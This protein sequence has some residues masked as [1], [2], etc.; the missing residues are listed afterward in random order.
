MNRVT[1]SLFFSGLFLGSGPCLAICGPVLIS[2]IVATRLNTK[3]AIGAWFLFS[4]SRICVYIL[5]GI[6]IFSIGDLLVRQNL[7]LVTKYVSL[8]GGAAIILAGILTILRIS[9]I[10]SQI[11]S[12]FSNRMA[13]RYLRIQPIA[14]GSIMGLLPCMPLLAVLSYI[15][16]IALNWKSCLS[17]CLIFG[18]GTAISPLVRLVLGVGVIP[19]L[20]H[21]K[22]KV[23]SLFQLLS[24]LII[25]FF[26]IQLISR[27]FY[28]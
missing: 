17:Y 1:L 19:G 13:N 27:V 21:G 10:P 14:L 28:G 11:C 6:A 25:V 22:P 20:L 3:Q 4:I 12:S 16:L 2:Y 15:G 23:Y 9:I 7:T 8:I 5:L 24:G 18:L 26:G